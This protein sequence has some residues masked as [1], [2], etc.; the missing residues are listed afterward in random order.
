MDAE[1]VS[2]FFQKPNEEFREFRDYRFPLARL[3]FWAII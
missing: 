1:V 2:S 3:D